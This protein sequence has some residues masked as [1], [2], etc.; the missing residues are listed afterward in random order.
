VADDVDIDDLSTIMHPAMRQ[1]YDEERAF[2]LFKVERSQRIGKSM[3][4][5]LLTWLDYVGDIF[6]EEEI[7]IPNATSDV[8][9]DQRV[10]LVLDKIERTLGEPLD[11]TTRANVRSDIWDMYNSTSNSDD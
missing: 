1:A 5:E 9:R 3:I 11:E 2:I 6:E 7:D 10:R 4:Q 8:D